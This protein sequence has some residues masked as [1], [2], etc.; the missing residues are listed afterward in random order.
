MLIIPLMIGICICDATG[1]NNITMPGDNGNSRKATG[2]MVLY[3]GNSQTQERQHRS[4]TFLTIYSST[5]FFYRTLFA[6]ST[7]QLERNRG[8]FRS[9]IRAKTTRPGRDF[10][11]EENTIHVCSIIFLTLC[12]FAGLLKFSTPQL[13]PPF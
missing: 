12:S 10:V 9:S 7:G 3:E 13:G 5:H 2:A 6:P 11:Y 4:S 8:T 1:N